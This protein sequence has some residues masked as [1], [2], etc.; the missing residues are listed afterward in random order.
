MLHKYHILF[1]G[2]AADGRLDCFHFLAIVD[3]AAM[4]ILIQAPV[5][6]YFHF[7]W[8][9]AV[10]EKT[11]GLRRCHSCSKPMI[12][13]LDLIPDLIAI[14][15]SPG[16]IIPINQPGI[17]W[18]PWPLCP[19]QKK[20]EEI[21]RIKTFPFSSPQERSS[22]PKI[23]LSCPTLLPIETFHLYKRL[24]RPSSC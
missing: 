8:V 5:W 22:S 3:G 14:S 7:A 9:Y 15:A 23:V 2:S 17:F 11:T 13:N 18:S 19:P 4:S 10:K 12:P 21:C 16:N 1:A 20:E 24:E 6:L